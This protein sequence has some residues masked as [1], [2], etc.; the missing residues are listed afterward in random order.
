MSCS[1]G[2]EISIENWVHSLIMSPWY[3]TS[4]LPLVLWHFHAKS[5]QGWKET[6]FLFVWWNLWGSPTIHI[7]E[8][9]MEP[10]KWGG[11]Q[12]E[13]SLIYLFFECCFSTTEHLL[14]SARQMP[15]RPQV[16]INQVEIFCFMTVERQF[17]WKM[18]EKSQ[19]KQSKYW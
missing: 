6:L 15:N 17:H 4:C 5:G 3:K 9:S 12:G 10:K 7:S 13:K 11:G 19:Q 18:R 2:L 8:G 16:F 14:L 1:Q